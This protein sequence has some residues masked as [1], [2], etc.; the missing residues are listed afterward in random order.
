MFREIR[1]LPA[2]IQGLA[3]ALKTVSESLAALIVLQSEKGPSDAR[4]EQLEL[5]RATWEA[6]MDALLLKAESTLRSAANAESRART[7][8]KHAEKLTDPFAEEGE[9]VEDGVPPQYA[10]VGEG[11]AVQAMHP[12]VGV[13]SPKELALRMKFS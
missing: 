12:D 6:E 4:L 10:P 2:Q 7:M 11:E 8:M 13:L 9:E 3:H 5:S 1:S